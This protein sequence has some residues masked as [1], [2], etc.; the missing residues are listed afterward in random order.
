MTLAE[1]TAGGDYQHAPRIDR[2]EVRLLWH[3]DFWDGPMS[4]MLLY[5]GQECWFQMVAE[6]EDDASGWYR[7]FVV[8][9]LSPEQHAEELRWHGLFQ[10]SVG[11]H[12]DYPEIGQRAAGDVRPREQWSAFY[13]SYRKRTPRDFSGCDIS[14]WFEW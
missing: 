14:G 1:I 5:R 10:R 11:G 2:A 4:G 12:S 8:L 3:D 6:S 13:D 9:Q 7:R